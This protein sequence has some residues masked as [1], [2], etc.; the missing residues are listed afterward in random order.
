MTR[1]IWSLH[2]SRGVALTVLMVV[3]LVAAAATADYLYELSWVTRAGLLAI[4]AAIVTVLAAKWILRPALAWNRVRV[5]SELEGLFPRL[6]QRLRTATQHGDRS[7][8]ELTRDGVAPGLVAALEEETAEKVKPLPFQAAVPVRAAMVAGVIALGC[9]AAVAAVAVCV[10][11]WR[12]AVTR[13]GLARTPYTTL[14]A[15]PSAEVVDEGANVEIRA[16]MSGRI[17]PTVVLHVREAGET[18]WWQET[19][20]PVEGTFRSRLGNLRTTTEF[21][22]VAGPERTPVRQ[23][24]VRHALKI[25]GARAEVTSPAYTGLSPATHESGSFSA[26]Q[27]STARLRFDSTALLQLPRWS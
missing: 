21:F 13:V 24:V 6:G 11:E 9:V 19:M 14:E 17:R 3:A 18:D 23:V 20:D 26:V 27:G 4:G 7:T 8:D 25:V 10:P 5:A 12:T 16:T 1:Q 2:V 15:S 22:V